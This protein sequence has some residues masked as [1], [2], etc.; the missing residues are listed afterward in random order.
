MNCQQW[1]EA[2][3]SVVDGQSATVRLT[4][5]LEECVGCRELLDALREDQ[6]ELRLPPEI[7]L[8]VCEAVRSEAVRR[9]SRR[10]TLPIGWI[11]AAAAVI[12]MA[13][14]LKRDRPN[15]QPGE[16]KLIVPENTSISLPKPERRASP[17]VRKILRASRSQAKS[18]RAPDWE[19]LADEW[20]RAGG[21][22]QER[23]L[24]PADALEIATSDPNVVIL[25]L[26]EERFQ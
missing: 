19:H 21:L 14:L 7:P 6:T 20:F 22:P 18:R 2:I 8:D 1:E 11:A 5:H 10:K 15:N 26:K 13:L 3:A 24:P 9:F 16:T 4:E 25:L 12:L 17:T 23:V